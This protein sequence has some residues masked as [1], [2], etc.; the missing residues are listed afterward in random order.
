M[1]R[2]ILILLV[3][4]LAQ[5]SGLAQKVQEKNTGIELYFGYNGTFYN[6]F[7]NGDGSFMDIGVGMTTST[8]FEFAIGRRISKSFII[9]AMASI[10]KGKLREDIWLYEEHWMPS[11]EGVYYKEILTFDHIEVSDYSVAEI[12]IFI[13]IGHPFFVSLNPSMVKMVDLSYNDVIQ[14]GSMKVGAGILLWRRISLEGGYQ[15][16]KIESSEDYWNMNAPYAKLAIS[17][18]R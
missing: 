5:F 4:L 9:G 1:K 16:A 18:L 11:K 2:L 8:S 15:F 6:R 14:I 3:L 7:E 17:L 13:K 12:G 10:G